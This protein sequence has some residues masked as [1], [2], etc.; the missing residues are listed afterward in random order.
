[1]A[2]QQREIDVLDKQL[3]ALEL[4]KAGVRYSDIAK[5]LGYKSASGAFAAVRSA[6]IK[7]LREPADELRALELE[8][9]DA[10]WFTYY[11]MAKRGDLQAMDRCIKIMERRAKMLGID[12]PQRT[13][14][15]G[16]GGGPIQIEQYQRALDMVYGQERDE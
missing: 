10:L 5:N 2:N 9:L 3:Q 4:R 1:M 8:R 13:E 11:P 14:T 6:L 15:T 7:T 16:A 12:A